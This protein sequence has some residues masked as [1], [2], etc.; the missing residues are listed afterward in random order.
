MANQEIEYYTYASMVKEAVE[1]KK[2]KNCTDE[3][4]RDGDEY[5]TQSKSIE[6]SKKWAIEG[7]D[8]GLKE[9]VIEDGLLVSGSTELAPSLAGCIPHVQN[10]IMGFPE[11]MYALHDSRE[12]NLP[13]MDIVVNLAYSAIVEGEDALK[14]S[15]SIV[16]FINAKASN[17]NI[18]VTGVFATK[19]D[20]VDT[21]QVITLKDFDTALVINNIAFAFHP[22]FFRRLWFSILEGKE[23]WS[24]GYGRPFT[25]Y[26]RVISEKLT[27]S[28]SD[29]VYFFKTLSD[30]SSSYYDWGE[31]DI[32]KVTY[33]Q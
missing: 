1:R 21:F 15:K 17:Y 22:S 24:S 8:L 33:Q 20:S 3:S 18:R 30:L 16:S 9:Y 32:E 23:Y 27:G 11:E 10:H 4:S 14:F 5:F 25:R 13:T 2:H 28:K 29:K 26:D 19:Q 7:W 12:Y 6:E 31:K